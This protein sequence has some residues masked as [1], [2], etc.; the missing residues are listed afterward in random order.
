MPGQKK[1]KKP[2]L[3][4][5]RERCHDDAQFTQRFLVD[6]GRSA[7]S[8]ARQ[9]GF[10]REQVFLRFDV[11]TVVFAESRAVIYRESALHE[12]GIDRIHGIPVQPGAQVG[13]GLG[14]RLWRSV[15]AA[16]I[17]RISSGSAAT[18]ETV[19]N[20]TAASLSSVFPVG[21]QM[22]TSGT[23][24][25]CPPAGAC[26]TCRPSGTSIRTPPP[27]AGVR[28]S[29]RAAFTEKRSTTRESKV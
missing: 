26:S 8:Q 20:T 1:R 15:C 19:T 21:F 5:R 3:L 27:S 11:D 14:L 29:A 28:P 22:V 18:L 23:M 9:G 2:C 17:R 7:V 16:R 10:S 4:S 6:G 24:S 25:F 13:A 12:V